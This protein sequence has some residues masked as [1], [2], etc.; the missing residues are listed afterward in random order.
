MR[1]Y[2]RDERS[3]VIDTQARV[4]AAPNRPLR[5]VT[6]E[7]LSGGRGKQAF[8]STVH[9]ATAEQVLTWYAMRWSIE[10][11]FLD[12]K[13]HLGFEAPQGWSRKA[14]ERTAPVAMLLYS[15]IVLW[16]AEVGH[17]HDK[18]PNRPRYPQK[19]HAAFAD[20][21]ATLRR[22]SIRQQV[23]QT[24][25]AGPGSRKIRKTLDTALQAAA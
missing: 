9:D 3:R 11:T 1:I 2:G 10:V 21:L 6:V 25:L 13:Q 12:T 14:A 20:M 4:H 18:P 17:R 8:Y 24:G 19:P 5:V 23:L 7:P 15:L 22:V 16:F